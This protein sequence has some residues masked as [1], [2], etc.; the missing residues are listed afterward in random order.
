MQLESYDTMDHSPWDG[1]GG[2]PKSQ[3]S[4]LPPKFQP[5]MLSRP[6]ATDASIW[7]RGA[8]FLS[9]AVIIC[10]ANIEA[11]ILSHADRPPG[12]GHELT[13]ELSMTDDNRVG[14]L[15]ELLVSIYV[16]MLPEADWK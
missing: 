8:L 9:R 7:L 5:S 1:E 14:G 13:V 6:Q 16:M 4:I 2:L 11:Q 12:L 10:R 3:P 15:A